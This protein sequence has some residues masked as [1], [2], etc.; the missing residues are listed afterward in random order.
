MTD[1]LVWKP[2][3]SAPY[4]RVVWVR[5]PQM[6]EPCK[7]TRGYVHNGM[8]HPDQSFFTTVYTPHRFFPTPAGKLCCP[9]E[10]AEIEDDDWAEIEDDDAEDSARI[11]R[12]TVKRRNTA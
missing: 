7:A 11:I 6:D 3:E 2:I 5:N 12:E 4:Q 10:W 8:V 9:V 1:R